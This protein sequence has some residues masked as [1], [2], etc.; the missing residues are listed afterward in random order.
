[1]ALQVDGTTVIDDSR[2]ITNLGSALTVAQGGTGITSFGSGVANFLGTP[3]SSNLATAVTG[4]TGSGAL[5]FGTSPTLAGS[6][7]FTGNPIFNTFIKEKTTVA[8]TAATGTVNFDLSTQG[9]VYYTTDASGNWTLNVR[10]DASNSLDSLM[11][12]GEA[13]TLAF[14]VTNGASAY[15]QSGFEI[16]GSAVTPEFQG[17]SAHSS[18]NANSI[19]AYLTTIIKTGSGTFKVLQSLTQFA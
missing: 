13:V 5:V 2:N 19:D 18:G 17:G 4:E 9:V 14:L 8:A 1:M 10:G 15:Y 12:T 7:T 11:S 3:S 16:D 6:I